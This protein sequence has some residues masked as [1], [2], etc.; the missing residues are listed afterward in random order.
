MYGHASE[1]DAS[2]FEKS[3]GKVVSDHLKTSES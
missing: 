2:S 1:A 3:I